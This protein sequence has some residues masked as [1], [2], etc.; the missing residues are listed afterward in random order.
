MSK[1]VKPLFFQRLVNRRV[2]LSEG[3]AIVRHNC[4]YIN[5]SVFQFSYPSPSFS[6]CRQSVHIALSPHYCAD[7]YIHN[8]V[9]IVEPCKKCI[10]INAGHYSL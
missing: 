7:K 8:N 5:L 3:H 6:S 2:K 4:L 9:V 1:P 10:I